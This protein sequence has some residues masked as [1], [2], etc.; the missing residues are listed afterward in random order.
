MIDRVKQ[1]INLSSNEAARNELKTVT[2]LCECKAGKK[3]FRLYILTTENFDH[4]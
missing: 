4:D 3:Y 2:G 1:I